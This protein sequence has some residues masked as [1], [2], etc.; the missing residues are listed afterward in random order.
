[1]RALH[2]LSAESFVSFLCLKRFVKL[3][4]LKT[5]VNGCTY[6]CAERAIANSFALQV[7]SA[8]VL[9]QAV[10]SALYIVFCVKQRD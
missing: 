9:L 10:N 7:H 5:Y 8:P 6:I 2:T 4:F 1:M 3:P